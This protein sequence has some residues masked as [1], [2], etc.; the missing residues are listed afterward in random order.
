MTCHGDVFDYED[1]SKQPFQ[2]YHIPVLERNNQIS[3]ASD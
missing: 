2:C 1:E 3:S